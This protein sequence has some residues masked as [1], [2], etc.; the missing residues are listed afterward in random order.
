M[1]VGA[2][3][4]TSLY[5]RQKN[6]IHNC[7]CFCIFCSNYISIVAVAPS[8]QTVRNEQSNF[9]GRC[10][11]QAFVL[12]NVPV[13]QSTLIRGAEGTAWWKRSGLPRVS[14]RCCRVLSSPWKVLFLQVKQRRG[15]RIGYWGHEG[16]QHEAPLTCW[17]QI[18]R[19]PGFD[20]EG[21][22]VL[23][24]NHCTSPEA[25]QGWRKKV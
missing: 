1:T 5:N 24:W 12:L 20:S 8:V 3:L 19:I 4:H 10:A 7:M 25:W 21:S 23:I 18:L 16:D 13:V 17:E 2:F 15:T 22:K 6:N 14:V 11:V 9:E